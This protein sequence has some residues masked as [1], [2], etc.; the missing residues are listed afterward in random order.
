MRVRSLAAFVAVIL[1]RLSTAHA[2]SRADIE[3]KI[4]EAMESYDLMDYDASKKLLNQALAAAKKFKLDKDVVTA[5]A[6]LDLGIVSFVNNDQ[7]GAKLSFL[8]AC[9]IDPKIQ[10]DPAYKSPEMAKLLETARGEAKGSGGGGGDV[11]GNEGGVDLP[12]GDGGASGGDGDCKSVKGLQHELIDSAKAG[13]ALSVTAQLGGDVHA[14]KVSVMYRPEGATTFTEVK[15]TKQ[16]GCKYVAQIPASGMHGSLVHYYVA[17]YGDN[18]KP[19][20]SKGSQGSPNIMELTAG[21]GGKAGGGDNEDPLGGG[22]KAGEGGGGGGGE[23][24]ESGGEVDKGTPGGP[25][26]PSK[27]MIAASA[28]LGAGLLGSSDMTEGGNPVKSSG[29]GSSLVLMPELA[30]T[31]SPQIAIGVVG[32][33]ALPIGANIAGHSPVG[34]AGMLRLRYALSSSGDGVHVMAQAG[35]G[36]LRSTLKLDNA[37][38]GMDVDIVAQGPLILGGG[39]GYAKHFGGSAI[40]LA[41]LSALAGIAVVNTVGLAPMNTGLTV[42]LS[43]GI[44]YGL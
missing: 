32:R 6:Y 24:T 10:I 34:P 42:D 1:V 7:D 33:F 8:S 40:F 25:P 18:G 14:T 41:D 9:Q 31:L 28:G 16:G 12:I 26:K 36:I 23:T 44:A 39:L 38:P 2:D 37:M 20:A 19:V 35:G 21:G 5:R 3:K 13:A 15:M 4:K 30:Y 17:A 22:K 43:I 27:V 29:F 11:G